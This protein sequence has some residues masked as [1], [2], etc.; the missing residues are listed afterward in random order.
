MASIQNML[1]FDLN[2]RLNSRFVPKKRT[3]F[4]KSSELMC[5]TCGFYKRSMLFEIVLYKNTQFYG[6]NTQ[7][8]RS[9]YGKTFFRVSSPGPDFF[10]MNG[11]YAIVNYP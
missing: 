9:F 6:E 2:S 11:Q 7:I 8:L 1:D 3:I 10:R 4:A 5:K